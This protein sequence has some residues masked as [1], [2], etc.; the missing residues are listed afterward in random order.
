MKNDKMIWCRRGLGN[1]FRN[2]K[3]KDYSMM[4]MRAAVPI[5]GLVVQ[6]RGC[7]FA[8]WDNGGEDFVPDQ[9]ARSAYFDIDG[10]VRPRHQLQARFSREVE[11]KATCSSIFWPVQL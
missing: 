11:E 10:A 5:H 6:V 9:A 3:H 1:W 7:P 2:A 4:Q 8:I